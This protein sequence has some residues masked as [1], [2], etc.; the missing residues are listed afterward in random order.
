MIADTGKPAQQ[1]GPNDEENLTVLISL[2]ANGEIAVPF[3]VF[4]Y[5]RLTKENILNAMP[6]NWSNRKSDSGGISE[7]YISCYR[8]PGRTC[9]SSE[10][11]TIFCEEHIE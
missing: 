8:F 9:H 1:V 10:S 11:A 2:N 3:A 5:K 4:A 6:N 7:R